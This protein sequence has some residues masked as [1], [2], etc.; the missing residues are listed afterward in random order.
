MRKFAFFA[1]ILAVTPVVLNNP[2]SAQSTASANSRIALG[3]I[4]QPVPTSRFMRVH[5]QA[6]PPYGFVRFCIQYDKECRPDNRPTTRVVAGPD[7]LSQLDTINRRV[8]TAIKPATDREIYGVDEYWTFPVN[9]GDCED[10]VILKRKLLM[11]QG[12]PASTLLITV[13]LDERGEGHAVLTARTAQGDFILDNKVNDVR[14][15]SQTPYSY[16]M[17]QSYL[18]PRVWVSLDSGVSTSPNAIAGVRST[19]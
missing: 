2:A 12:W 8:N 11:D 7:R 1:A 3:T 19:R 4:E 6:L 9:R 15:W 18:D 17:R 5:G 16:V 14:L 13:V 10:Y